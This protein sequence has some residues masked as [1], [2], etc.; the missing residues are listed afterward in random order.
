MR[1]ARVPLYWNCKGWV[2]AAAAA[3]CMFELRDEVFGPVYFWICSVNFLQ[4]AVNKSLQIHNVTPRRSVAW[5]FASTVQRSSNPSENESTY[6][7]ISYTTYKK[8]SSDASEQ[9]LGRDVPYSS[10]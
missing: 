2:E 4:T 5:P 3:A 6:L 9:M 7:Q 8:Q 1:H 10:L